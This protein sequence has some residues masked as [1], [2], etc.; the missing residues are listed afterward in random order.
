MSKRSLEESRALQEADHNGL[1]AI[2]DMLS[3]DEREP[4]PPAGP[5]KKPRNFIATV[6]R[7]LPLK[8]RIREKLLIIL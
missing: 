6:V 5:S 2:Q 4:T 8:S 1:M 3:P 7:Y